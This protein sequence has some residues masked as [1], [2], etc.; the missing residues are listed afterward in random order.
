MLD[1]LIVF[2]WSISPLGEGRV[3]IPVG[4]GSGL[5]V[6]MTFVVASVANLLVFPLF[7]G[8]IKLGNQYFWKHRFYK[9]GAIKLA[10]RAK[11]GTQKKI[12]KYGMLGLMV[13]VMIPLPGTGAYIGTLAAFIFDLPYKKSFLAVSAGVLIALIITVLA[14]ALVKEGVTN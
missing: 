11:Q 5:S 7:Y 14:S 3:G 8:L 9:R 13:L 1:Y 4:I 10:R 12:Q 6:V 2:L